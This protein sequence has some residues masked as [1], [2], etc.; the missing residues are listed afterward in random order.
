MKKLIVAVVILAAIGA[1]VALVFVGRDDANDTNSVDTSTTSSQ[2]T[3]DTQ[4]G[5]EVA[6]QAQEQNTVAVKDFAFMPGSITVKKGTTV[7]WTNQDSTPHTVTSSG[8]GEKVMDS[9]DLAQGGMYSVTFDTAGTYEYFCTI[10][11]DMTGTI[12]VTE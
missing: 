6:P 9:R 11:P 7:M 12:T 5:E 1:V 4:T 10:H 3:N 8:S 2:G